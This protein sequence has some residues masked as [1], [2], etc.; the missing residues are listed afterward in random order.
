MNLSLLHCK[1]NSSLLDH[2]GSSPLILI[3]LL[4]WLIELKEKFTSLLKDMTK[5]TSEQSD[6]EIQRARDVATG[7]ELPALSLHLHV[8]TNWEALLIL[9]IWDFMETSPQRQDQSLTPISFLLPS[10][11]NEG[12]GAGLKT[13]SF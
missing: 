9:Y 4:E 2:Q 13:L 6:E 10:Q 1:V 12:V 5:D 11:E 8:F 3:D 7:L